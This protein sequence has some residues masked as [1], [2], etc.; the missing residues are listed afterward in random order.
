MLTRH[1]G[2]DSVSATCENRGKRV[3]KWASTGSPEQERFRPG[4]HLVLQSGFDTIRDLVRSQVS[5]EAQGHGHLPIAFSHHAGVS[6]KAVK[7]FEK[8]KM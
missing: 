7:G 8:E 5:T 6:H 3:V 2:T 4:F 1:A